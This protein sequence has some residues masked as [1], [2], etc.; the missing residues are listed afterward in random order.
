MKPKPH[1]CAAKEIFKSKFTRV[2]SLIIIHGFCWL[3]SHCL[4]RQIL[5]KFYI[6]IIFQASVIKTLVDIFDIL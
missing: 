4:E 1:V 3:L 6:H 5:F 2:S